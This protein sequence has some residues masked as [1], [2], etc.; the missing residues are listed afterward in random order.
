MDSYVLKT[1]LILLTGGGKNI[2]YTK[3]GVALRICVVC[4][5]RRNSY[6]SKQSVR[7]F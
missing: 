1:R 2:L 4:L 6:L 3:H 5:R 7:L